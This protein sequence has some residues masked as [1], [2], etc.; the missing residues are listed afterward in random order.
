M[1]ILRAA[2]PAM[3]EAEEHCKNALDAF[4]RRHYQVA[5]ITWTCGSRN[6][7]PDYFL[8]LRRDSYAVEVT[9][10]L[11]KATLGNRVKD[12]IEIDKSVKR[13]IED[14]KR[15]AIDTGIL[16]GAYVVAY[17]PITDFGKQKQVIASRIMDYLRR[18]Q[19]SPSAPP[20]GIVGEGKSKWCI[21][22]LH[23]GKNYLSRTASD[24]R[25][26]GEAAE[27]LSNPWAA[28]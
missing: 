1:A 2:G 6:E 14:V 15:D 23:S 10:V 21:Y 4:L 17:K 7:P 16:K 22:K 28:H 26:E 24:A 25:W 12:H 5:D 8:Q 3:R 27:E 9:S 13:F 11:E 20:E 18:T 19:G